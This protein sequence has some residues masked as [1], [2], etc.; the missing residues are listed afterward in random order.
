MC[1]RAA[2][3]N[4]VCAA[5]R[6]APPCAATTYRRRVPRAG[7][8]PCCH[9]RASHRTAFQQ[10][11]RPPCHLTAPARCSGC[12]AQPRVPSPS[13]S[14]AS[15]TPVQWHRRAPASSVFCAGSGCPCVAAPTPSGRLGLA[16]AASA[17][18][19]SAPGRLPACTRAGCSFVQLHPVSPRRVLPAAWAAPPPSLLRRASRSP[20]PAFRAVSDRRSACRSPFPPSASQLRAA[21]PRRVRLPR[22]RSHSRVGR[23]FAPHRLP[24]AA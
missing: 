10:W 11:L 15:R 19:A 23:P 9:A 18:S 7:A 21:S 22:A 16:M 2:L 8:S 4:P 3:C 17:C 24:C 6:N 13:A 12:A 14:S 1:P 20:A 5:A